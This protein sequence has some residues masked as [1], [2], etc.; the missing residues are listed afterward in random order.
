MAQRVAEAM[1]GTR[2]PAAPPPLPATGP[3]YW[4]AI[5][6]QQQGPFDAEA[7]AGLVKDGKLGPA[8]L[9]WAEGMA[10]W[11]K[12]A[13]RADLQ[14]ILSAAPPPLPPAA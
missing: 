5:G 11:A 8:S 13:E 1:A 4:V 7:L 9:V 3:T 2:S 14:A 12:A 6:G 10:G